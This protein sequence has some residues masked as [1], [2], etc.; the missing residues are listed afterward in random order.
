[1]AIRPMKA[2]ELQAGV[3]AKLLG[4]FTIAV[5]AAVTRT[6]LLGEREALITPIMPA[7]DRLNSS[8]WPSLP[9]LH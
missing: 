1:M 8:E 7:P 4:M 9:P 2:Y 6:W 3:S 5:M